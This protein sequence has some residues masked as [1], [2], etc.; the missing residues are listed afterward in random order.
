MTGL[1]KA[2]KGAK[3]AAGEDAEEHSGSGDGDAAADDDD[4]QPDSTAVW[5]PAF[6]RY[7]VGFTFR[8]ACCGHKLW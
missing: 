2:S 5:L 7:H 4:E 3:Q 1:Q 8:L 6:L